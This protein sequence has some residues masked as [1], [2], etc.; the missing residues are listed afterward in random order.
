MILHSLSGV[1]QLVLGRLYFSRNATRG[2]LVM[3]KGRPLLQNHGAIVL[4]D[5]VKIWSVIQR[6][7]IFVK[8]NASLQIG[9]HTFINGVHLSVSESVS[10]GEH[11]DIGPY[12]VIIDDDFHPVGSQEDVLRK[13]IVIED[14]VWITM[15]CM[16]MK[17][18][19]IGKGAVVAAGAVVTKD[20]PPYT[21]VGG[22]PAKVIKELK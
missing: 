3:V 9:S 20:V 13:P 16:I 8:R 1:T 2:K 11:V 4:G 5:Q 10:I 19:R 14:H 15:N 12:T 7:K 6:S 18:V 22:V 17:G 21:L